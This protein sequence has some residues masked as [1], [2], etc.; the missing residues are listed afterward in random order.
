MVDFG[1]LRDPSFAPDIS[2]HEVAAAGGMDL[3]DLRFTREGSDTR[4]N[5]L[6]AM[7]RGLVRILK[8]LISEGRCDGVF[9]LGGSGGSSVIAEAMR[10]LPLGLPKL[11][12]STMASGNVGG[13]IGTKD[14]AIM[15]SVTDIAGLNRVSKPIL[16]NAAFGI[17]GMAKGGVAAEES[18]RP[19]IA[20]SMFGITT[21]G[22]LRVV[23]RLEAAGFE[24]IVFHANGSG[25]AME[26]LIDQGLID[27]VIDFTPKELTDYTMGAVFH[28]GPGRLEA[29]GR[30][31][32]PQVIVPGGIEVMNFG[33]LT[34]MPEK[35][36]TLDRKVIVHNSLVCAARINLEESIQM[37]TLLA[38]KTNAAV[39][40]TAV[41]VPLNGFDMYEMPPDGPWI[42]REKDAALI[43]GLR[44]NLRSGISYHELHANINDPEFADTTVTVFQQMWQQYLTKKEAT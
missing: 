13:Y 4:A 30:K 3:K 35:Y 28:A 14:I 17:A 27:G 21:P 23:E 24:T 36:K 1:V 41:V 7:T 37:G 43:N 10:S 11:L 44:S 39:G 5:A 25:R 18:T 2:A 32:I 29:A 12:L 42:D 31:G 22:G 40:P 19:L 26:E 6:A 9:G 15:Y 33:P 8:R 16:R 38:K 20:V 34:T